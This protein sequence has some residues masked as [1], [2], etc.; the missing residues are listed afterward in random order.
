[1]N[2]SSRD[3]LPL[4]GILLLGAL[5][6]LWGLNWPAMK[7]ALGEVRPWTF[8]ALC[9]LTGGTGLLAIARARGQPL[10]IS[11]REWWPLAIVT[12]FNITAWHMLSAYGL[13]L[14]GAGR[15][16]II[17]YT[18]PLWAVILGRVVLGEPLTRFRSVALLLGLAGLAIL[19]G[20]EL[21]LLLA[22]PAGVLFMLGAAAAWATGTVM[23][24]HFRWT[25]PTVLLTGWQ[26]LLG[27]APVVL[28]QLVLEP[29]PWLAGVSVKGVLGTAY[30]AIVGTLVCHYAWFRV[31][32]S[33]PSGVAAIGTLGIPMVGVF[34]S[35]W[36]LG[37]PVG[38]REVAALALVVVAL[39]LVLRRPSPPPS[40]SA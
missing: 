7:V 37:E 40:L 4:T 5:T 22:A 16:V 15:A 11:R 34:S 21:R 1:M 17:A 29:W 18:M 2:S 38:A 9:L 20:P 26:L 14:V 13:T 23:L 8:R 28:G 24:K 19:I 25:M 6:I 12:F 35:G 10:A 31:V 27:G 33:L 30:A 32:R 39:A 36:L 3:L